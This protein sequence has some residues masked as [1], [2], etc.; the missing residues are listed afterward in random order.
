MTVLHSDYRSFSNYFGHC[1]MTDANLK[2]CR[3][4]GNIDM[5][6]IFRSGQMC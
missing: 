1:P 2:P 3:C 6:M 5:M 4:G